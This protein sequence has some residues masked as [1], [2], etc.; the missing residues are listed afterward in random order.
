MIGQNKVFI[1]AEA[2]VNHNGSIE[3]ARKLIDAAKN[4]GV[5]AVKFQ[6]WKT[7]NVVTRYAGSPEYQQR[8][9]GNNDGQFELLKKLELPYQDFVELKRYCD[10]KNIMFMSTADEYESALF[11][12][13]LVSVIK[14]ASSELTDWPFLRKIAGF[15]KQVILST[16]MSTLSEVNDALDVL[17]KSGLCKE[18]IV[19]LHANTEYPTPAE[20]VNLKA[21][22]TISNSL[23]VRV[24]YSDH[25]LG[26]EIPIAAVALGA[27]VIEKHFTLDRNM[28]G[29]DHV[30]SL[31]PDELKIMVNAIRN[32]EIALGDG[33]K[34]PS[35]SE[36]KNIP[37]ARKSIVA[38]VP[39]KKGDILNE[40]NMTV[41]RPGRGLSP[42]QWDK[43]IGHIAIK[44]YDF[45]EYIVI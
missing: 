29:P 14:V 26:I 33:L 4:A 9:T 24:G 8:T 5:D 12:D 36:M 32:I 15:D 34:H 17:N 2:G 1:I 21:M 41:K 3:I 23:N 20:D 44:D 37:L 19:V 27:C 43:V 25:T 30:A 40:S 39:I 13:S 42:N 10:E 16:G 38:K 31:E 11:L 45:D 35:K 28:N 6:T 22:Q 7:E 18:K